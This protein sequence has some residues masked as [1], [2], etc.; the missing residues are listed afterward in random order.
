MDLNMV[1]QEEEDE[2]IDLNMMPQEEEEEAQ[3]GEDGS[4]DLNLMPQE[5]EE[6]AQHGEDGGI[7][8][9]MMPQ[10]EEEEA[11]PGED[12]A[13]N[14]MPQED[15]DEEDEVMNWI[16]QEDEEGQEGVPR[17]QKRKELSN[18]ERNAVYFALLVIELRDGS[19]QPN[20]KLL[21]SILLNI[22]VR[23]VERIWSDAKKQIAAGQEVDVSNKKKGRVGRERKEL[24][25]ARTSTIPLNRRRTIRSLARSLGVARSTLHRRFQLNELNRTTNTVKTYLKPENKIARL[26]FLEPPPERTVTN[27]NSIGKVSVYKDYWGIV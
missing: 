16:L 13:M 12:E 7:D 25:L 22:H 26:K 11:Q 6:E 27:I 23:S 8:L 20:D 3:Q 18:K 4:I 5:E 21:V 1:P 10:E 19:V 9:N 17:K 24:D 14:W 15:E 2:G